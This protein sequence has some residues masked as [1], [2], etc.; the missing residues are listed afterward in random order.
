M[1]TLIKKG[2]M[3]SMFGRLPKLKEDIYGGVKT[4][5]DDDDNE[6]IMMG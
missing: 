2:F 6:N 3:Y 1:F 4:S 5:A